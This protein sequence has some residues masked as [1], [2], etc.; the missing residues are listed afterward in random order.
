MVDKAKL[1]KEKNNTR[2]HTMAGADLQNAFGGL[3]DLTGHGVGRA[4]SITGADGF[5]AI[6]E[7]NS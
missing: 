2:R 5:G 3:D 6:L 4:G 1:S 7:E